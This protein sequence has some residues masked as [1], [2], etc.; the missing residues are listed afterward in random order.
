MYTYVY[1][2]TTILSTEH[3]FHALRMTVLSKL[4]LGIANYHF[5]IVLLQKYLLQ[6]TRQTALLYTANCG[7]TEIA[8]TLVEMGADIHLTDRVQQQS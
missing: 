7:D 4:M 8:E 2:F 1:I 3:V 6:E 5:F